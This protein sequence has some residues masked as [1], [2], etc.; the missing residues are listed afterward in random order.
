VA[1]G[2]VTLPPDDGG[3]APLRQRLTDGVVAR[4]LARLDTLSARVDALPEDETPGPAYGRAKARAWLDLARTEYTDN[5]GTGIA[6]FAYR[7][8][9]ALADTLERGETPGRGE[10]PSVP[11]SRTVRPELWARVGGLHEH[12]GFECVAGDV[13]RTEVLL[14]WAGNEERSYGSADPR[15]LAEAA[16]A[17]VAT[18]ES[19]AASCLPP[20]PPPPEPEPQPEPEPEPEPEPLPT[21]FRLPDAVHF[22][23]EASSLAPESRAVLDEVVAALEARPDL[24]V[25]LRGHPDAFQDAAAAGDLARRRVGTAL[26]YLVGR[27]IARERI[28]VLAPAG[29]QP[30]APPAGQGRRRI[31]VAAWPE[32]DRARQRRV[33]LSYVAPEGVTVEVES[34]ERDLQLRGG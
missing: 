14:V 1:A 27:G 17:L 33:E 15:S 16:E 30:P 25:R 26:S 10:T 7:R 23:F 8:A 34:Q 24:R 11:G 12:E 19:T 3:L 21:F 13:A 28:I 22:A 4:D 32:L 31:Q 2:C 6:D 29:W 5:D 20:P 18:A 9:S